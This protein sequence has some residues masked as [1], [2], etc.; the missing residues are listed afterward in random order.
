MVAL[1]S[2]LAVIDLGSNSARI[3]VLRLDA[4]GQLDIVADARTSLQL[5][6]RIDSRGR[7]EAS[8]VTAAIAA[9]RDFRAVAAAAGAERIVAVAT[10]AIRTATNR[11]SVLAKLEADTGLAIT[12]IDGDQEARYAF[13]GAVHGLPID[14]GY[15][16]DVGGG[17]FELAYFE[18]RRALRWWTFELGA[19]ITTDQFLGT[20]PPRASEVAALRDHVTQTLRDAGVPVLPEDGG[21]VGTGGTVRNLA[22]IHM[23]SVGHPIAR[24]DG[25]VLQ[26]REV[27]DLTSRLVSRNRSSL[28]TVPGLSTDRADSITGG[29]LVVIAAMEALGAR[30]LMVSGHG[31]REGIALAELN[32]PLPEVWEVRHGSVKA[33]ASRFATWDEGRAARRLELVRAILGVADPTMN[34]EM[35]EV[36]DHATT[37]LDIGQ[38]IN[39]YDR[40]SH[41]AG[42]TASADLQGFSHREVALIATTLAR[43]GKPRSNLPRYARLCTRDDI[44]RIDRLAVVIE[45]ADELDRRVNG[46]GPPTVRYDERRNRVVVTT[47][48]PY[49]WEPEDISRRFRTRLGRTLSLRPSETPGDRTRGV[50][51]PNGRS[52]DRGPRRA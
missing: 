12:V 35:R 41:A 1:E 23:R 42:V 6:R 48:L 17:S 51:S 50:D 2:P 8:A 38:S 49:A 33:L 44:K 9:V 21:M 28:R 40:W 26:R 29:A 11:D 27:R 31:L 25:Y 46:G 18:R 52:T 24:V 14:T 10:A 47:G 20:D 22:K 4:S 13:L 43:L 30:N 45:L 5:A 34:A 36:L 32:L 19:L 7:L 37:L 15:L 16:I 3:A 39:Y